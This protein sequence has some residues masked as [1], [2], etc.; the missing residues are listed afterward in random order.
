MGECVVRAGVGSSE[1]WLSPSAGDSS[2]P[3]AGRT[4]ECLLG[5]AGWA[6]TSSSSPHKDRMVYKWFITF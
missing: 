5:G 3:L 2:E 6:A 1:H 4:P